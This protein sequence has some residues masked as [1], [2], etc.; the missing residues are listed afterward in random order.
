MSA[1]TL[2]IRTT[3]GYHL[4]FAHK[5][6]IASDFFNVAPKYAQRLAFSKRK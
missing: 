6:Y 2:F 4:G 5:N 1:S 3:L